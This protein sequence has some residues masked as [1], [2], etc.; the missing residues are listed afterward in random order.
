[1][2][3]CKWGWGVY[4]VV[5]V[6]DLA[7][8][9]RAAAWRAAPCQSAPHHPMPDFVNSCH[10]LPHQRQAHVI[11]GVCI[12]SRVRTNAKLRVSHPRTI[13]YVH[14]NMP[15]DNSN[16]PWAWYMFPDSCLKTGRSTRHQTTL[17]DTRQRTVHVS[18]LVWKW[19]TQALG[20]AAENK[21][22]HKYDLFSGGT[23][24]LT[25]LG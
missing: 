21:L 6:V 23:S 10:A 16:I 12:R 25:L 18:D 14:F 1:M 4:C 11:R 19:Q 3:V 17:N 7:T 22:A 20:C 9:C 13:A 15:L 5:P 2:S 8:P 24:C